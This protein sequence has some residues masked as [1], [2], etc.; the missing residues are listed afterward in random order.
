M[1]V[2]NMGAKKRD[3]PEHYASGYSMHLYCDHENSR[4]AFQEFPH[5]YDGET[6]AECAKAAKAA[7]WKIHRKTRT[8]TCP[9]CVK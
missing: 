8:A 1:A 3:K 9:R 4:H 5:E 7:G 2:I 6:F